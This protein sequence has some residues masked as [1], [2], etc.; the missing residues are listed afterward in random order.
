MG[1]LDGIVDWLAT[2][3]MNLL[4]ELQLDRGREAGATQGE[5]GDHGGRVQFAVGGH[6]LDAD[7]GL[8]RQARKV[9]MIAKL[10]VVVGSQGDAIFPPV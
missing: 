10:A 2:Q 9:A 3:V 7:L 1:I 5:V 4:V 6:P 8:D